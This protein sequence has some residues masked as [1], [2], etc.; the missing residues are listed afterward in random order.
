MN[1]LIIEV[2][3]NKAVAVCESYEHV[4][5]AT[6]DGLMREES[7]S[8]WGSFEEAEKRAAEVTEATG[9]LYIATDSGS[10]CYPRFDVV[11]PPAVGDKV[12]YAFNGDYYPDGEV[13]KVSPTLKKVETSTGSV[14]YRRK[15]TGG[16]K[17]KGGT[18]SLINGHH[19]ERNPH[20]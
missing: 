12:S 18:W 7:R 20:F 16:W 13:V 19:N 8:N 3:T 2:A 9:V 6:A 11:R 4:R 14:Y 10:G 17:K 15:L 1:Y 5:N